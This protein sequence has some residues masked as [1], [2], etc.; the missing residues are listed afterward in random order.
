MYKR[1]IQR[2][3]FFGAKKNI[4]LKAVELRE[5]MTEAEMLLW[6]E[7]SNREIFR[8]KFRRQHPIDIFIVDFYCHKCKL[9][10]EVDGGIHLERIVQEYD[11][12][13]THDL[14]SLGIKVLRFSN[15]E[16]IEDIDMVKFRILQEIGF[17]S[18]L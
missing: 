2:N 1:V 13:R 7:L 3:M 17:L 9:A 4:F 6:K 10:I 18:P 11:D 15:Q 8:V 5:N 12:G 16:I 14:E